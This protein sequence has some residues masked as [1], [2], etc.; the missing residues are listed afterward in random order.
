M[1]VSPP[2][3][4][5]FQPSLGFVWIL[6]GKVAQLLRQSEFKKKTPLEQSG[7]LEDEIDFLL[8]FRASSQVVLTSFTECIL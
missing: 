1:K 7:W 8:G 2:G 5:I 4:N 3:S 6:R